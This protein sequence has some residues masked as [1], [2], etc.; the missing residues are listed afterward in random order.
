[1]KWGTI[2]VYG[3]VLAT[4]GLS[5]LVL[6]VPYGLP[7]STFTMVCAPVAG[8]SG[9]IIGN[10][11][12]QKTTLQST[13]R[14]IGILFILLFLTVI[15]I[16]LYEE[17]LD[18]ASPNA[19]FNFALY[20]LFSS[21]FFLLYMVMGIAGVNFIDKITQ[22]TSSKGNG[23]QQ[24][25]P[26]VNNIDSLEEEERSMRIL[27]LAANP[28]QTSPLDLE[29]EQRSLEQELRSVEFRD[30]ITLF[31]RHAVRPDDLLR[32]VR[33]DKPNVIH[34]SGHGSKAGIILRADNGTFQTVEGASLRR[35][36]NGRGIDLVVLNACYSKGQAE[37]IK[38]AVKSIVGT[39]DAVGDEAAR[40]FTVA[41][42]RSLGNGLSV[43]E[44]FRDGGD[45]VELHGLS[46]VF[47]SG[48]E[49]ALKLVG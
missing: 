40:R 1:M 33:A 5:S 16:F 8:I 31:A 25:R 36:L 34:F 7:A 6:D 22:Q 15:S 39:T 42:Y 18:A 24:T 45:A 35:F 32:Y 14:R 13:R 49:T 11:V 28:S 17:I 38:D 9:Y 3:V 2:G 12:S 26:R 47:H 37:D 19:V 10:H 23:K 29:E 43:A 30:S 46:D 21:I 44:A 4:S 20:L 48:G 41:F 27:F